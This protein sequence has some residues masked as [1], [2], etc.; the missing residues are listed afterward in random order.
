ML[1]GSEAQS[2]EACLVW[3]DIMTLGSRQLQ[4]THAPRQPLP[5][6][7]RLQIQAA[8]KKSS[9]K[10]I[11]LSKTLVARKGEEK[12][13][14][15]RCKDIVSFSQGRMSV[16]D[17]GIESFECT[18]D[19]YD[20]NVFHFWERYASNVAM[21]RHNN[22]PEMQAFMVDVRGLLLGC[23]PQPHVHPRSKEM[24]AAAGAGQPG[25]PIWHGL[26]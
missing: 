11:V 20:S 5:G 15:R 21:G 2:R 9:A 23:V 24:L 6:R 17:S 8:V 18:V 1:P 26:L 4:H 7:H 10:S 13:V 19:R 12:R 25:G 3:L 22:V 14:M 16:A